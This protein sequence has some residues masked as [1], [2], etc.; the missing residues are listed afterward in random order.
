MNAPT[1]AFR[2]EWLD[3][4]LALA[5]SRLPA[6]QRPMF[7]GFAREYFRQLDDD[8]LVERAREDLSGAVLS[9]WQF[10]AT[11]T[12]GAPKVRV[13]SPTLAEDGWASRHSV[14][15]I[16]NDDMPFLVDSTTTEINRQGLTLHLIVHPIFAVERDAGGRRVSIHP[17]R[18]APEAGRESW[19]HVEVDRLVDAQQRSELVA[20]I[21]RV[22]GDVRAAVEDWKPML[23]RLQEAIAELDTVPA[24]LPAAQVVESRA[25]LQWL[26]DES[27]HAA[28]LPAPRPRDG[29]RRRRAATRPRQRPRRAAGD[30]GRAVVGQLRRIA[31][32][33]PRPGARRLCRCWW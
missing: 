28:R 21:E 16:V 32:A 25:F 15:Q 11:R 7:E 9:H 20:G 27:L 1:D 6:E 18:E 17:R 23:A 31:A 2:L 22:L 4:V 19:M 3:T 13:L 24:S 5:A 8:D 29:A 33:G 10:G 30:R 12:P 26:A 14:I